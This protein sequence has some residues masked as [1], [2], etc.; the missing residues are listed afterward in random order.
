MFQP[1]PPVSQPGVGATTAPPYGQA[2]HGHQA[3]QTWQFDQPHGQSGYGQ[4]QGQQGYGE[5]GYGVPGY[6]QSGYGGADVDAGPHGGQLGGAYGGH[7]GA[8]YGGEPGGPSDAQPVT[9]GGSMVDRLAKVGILAAAVLA[10]SALLPWVSVQFLM[11]V[12]I[13]GVRA[14]EGKIVLVLGLVGVVL[15]ALWSSRRRTAFLYGT[16]AAGLLALVALIVC[17]VRMESSLSDALPPDGPFGDDL[18]QVAMLAV[19]MDFG[20]YLATLAA[21]VLIGTAA[22]GWWLNRRKTTPGTF[23]PNATFSGPPAT[24]QP[25]PPAGSPTAT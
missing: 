14:P 22:Y 5:P 9:A 16:A 6:G 18:E 2:S 1:P 11:S 20:W 12:S 13:I 8:T 25:T 21:L 7:A 23:P 3:G 15:A 19:G 10:F 24:P 4:A 17:G